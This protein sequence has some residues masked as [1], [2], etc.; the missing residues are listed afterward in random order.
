[1][2]D[3]T[4]QFDPFPLALGISLLIALVVG[5]VEAVRSKK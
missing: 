5:V 4:M 3:V 1:M 2:P